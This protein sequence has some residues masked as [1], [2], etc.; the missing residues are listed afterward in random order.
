MTIKLTNEVKQ[1]ETKEYLDRQQSAEGIIVL[2]KLLEPM[3]QVTASN[4]EKA[5][6][7]ISQLIDKL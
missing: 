5:N 6:N 1:S 4:V 2:S 3:L 7:K